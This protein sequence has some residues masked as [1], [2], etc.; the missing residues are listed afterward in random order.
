[1]FKSPG[2]PFRGMPKS[3]ALMSWASIFM[4]VT[5]IKNKGRKIFIISNI[6][7]KNNVLAKELRIY[8]PQKM[9][10]RIKDLPRSIF[11]SI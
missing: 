8:I 1:V 9:L 3:R 4:E 10:Y 5:R 2:V 6:Y 7:L 11:K